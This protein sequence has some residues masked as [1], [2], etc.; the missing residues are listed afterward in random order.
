MTITQLWD[1]GVVLL[2]LAM[3]IVVAVFLGIW[4]KGGPRRS[5]RRGRR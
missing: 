5:G 4:I 1:L 2:G 3:A